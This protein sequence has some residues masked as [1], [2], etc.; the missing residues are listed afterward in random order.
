MDQGCDMIPKRW[1]YVLGLVAVIVLMGFVSRSIK[2]PLNNGGAA[3]MKPASLWGSV[4]GAERCSINYQPKDGEAGT[5]L[6]WQDFFDRPIIVIP[7]PDDKVLL[8]LYD[9]DVDL[10]LLRIDPTKSPKPF[11][12]KSNLDA[13]VC[14]SPWC[15]ETGTTNDW[16]EMLDYLKSL[17]SGAFKRQSVPAYDLGII[18]LHGS[19]EYIQQW[20]EG[21]IK[22]MHQFG[23]TQWPVPNH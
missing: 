3:Q 17:P 9:F 23:A 12:P 10:R 7:A 1:L 22:F 15:I 6:L 19:P 13:I 2:V 21:Q 4:C 16:Q 20:M 18:R 5:V 8:C 11:P 14:A